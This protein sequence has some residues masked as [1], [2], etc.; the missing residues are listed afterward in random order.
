MTAVAVAGAAYHPR[1]RPA[2]V[3]LARVACTLQRLRRIMTFVNS[4]NSRTPTCE[5]RCDSDNSEGRRWYG[6]I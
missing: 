1:T 2:F 3:K 6:G 4:T 5:R